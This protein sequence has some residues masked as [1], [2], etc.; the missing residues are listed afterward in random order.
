MN[1]DVTPDETIAKGE[2][3]AHEAPVAIE[4]REA[5]HRIGKFAAYVAPAMLALVSTRNAAG[6]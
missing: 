3:E 1:S 2:P 4:R 5:V 6:S